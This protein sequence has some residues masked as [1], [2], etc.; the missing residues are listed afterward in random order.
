MINKKALFWLVLQ[1]LFLNTIFFSKKFIIGKIVIAHFKGI[2]EEAIGL[3]NSI[4]DLKQLI[5]N[6]LGEKKIKKLKIE[7][8]VIEEGDNRSLFSLGIKNDF[9]CYI[10][11]E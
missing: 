6:Y 1:S 8:N 9:T 10:E 2:G 3:L 11:K 7:N 4:N 5:L